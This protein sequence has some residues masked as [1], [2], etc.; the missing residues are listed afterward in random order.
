MF[1]FT[2]KNNKLKLFNYK[3]VPAGLKLGGIEISYH[4]KPDGKAKQKTQMYLIYVFTYLYLNVFTITPHAIISN[5]SFSLQRHLFCILS[6]SDF[7]A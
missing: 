2:A 1:S 6:T 4:V 3:C 7:K 5:V